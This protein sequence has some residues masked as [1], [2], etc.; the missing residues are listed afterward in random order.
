MI[1][2]KN[3]TFELPDSQVNKIK[4]KYL[5]EKAVFMGTYYL[6]THM[7]ALSPPHTGLKK[8]GYFIT[9]KKCNSESRISL[10]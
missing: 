10:G 4:N 3:F 7:D 2:A 1:S 8:F 9:R 6:D 5:K